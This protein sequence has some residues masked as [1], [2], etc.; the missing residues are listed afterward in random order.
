MPLKNVRIFTN[1]KIGQ[2]STIDEYVVIG[3]P[4]RGRKPGE[5]Q[6]VIGDNAIIRSHSVIYA[7]TKIG[8]CLETGH[9]VLI[10][11]NNV[12][13]NN[14][15]I[16]THSIIEND[17]TIGDKVRIHS[18]VFVPQRTIIEDEVWIGPNVI[19]LNDPHPPCAK[20]MRGPTLKKG[21]KIG[22]HATIMPF[23]VIGEKSLVG[24]GALVTRDV[25]P[26][27]VVTGSPA[28]IIKTIDDLECPFG[29]VEKPYG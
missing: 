22:A 16:G 14:V 25:S 15:R 12:I 21:A 3:R 6:T 9:G 17:N 5:L 10:R 18:A 11:E 13:G 23:V 27:A 19:L 2:G 24:A 1:V 29:I 20:C 28:K 26:R 8:N 4:P 7:G